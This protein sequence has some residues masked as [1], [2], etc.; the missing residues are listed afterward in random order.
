MLFTLAPGP[1]APESNAARDVAAVFGRARGQARRDPGALRSPTLYFYGA[2]YFSIKLIRYSLL[3]WL[4]YYLSDP[5]AY[6]AGTAGYVSVA[7]EVGGLAGVVGMGL[8]THRLQERV[9]TRMFASATLLVLAA[10]LFLYVRIAHFGASANVLG[11]A[12]I[13]ACL[14][15][16]D[17]LISGAVAQDAGGPHAAATATGLVNGVGSLGADSAG[18]AQRLGEPRVRL[19]RRVLR[20]RRVR[21]RRGAAPGSD[22]LEGQGSTRRAVTVTVLA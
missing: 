22:L 14:Y 9:A 4:P 5:F 3:F 15:G 18:R 7:F 2:S 16:P 17:S 19:A 10:S 20:V 1:G 12:L 8:I 21:G 13:G 6:S 11:L